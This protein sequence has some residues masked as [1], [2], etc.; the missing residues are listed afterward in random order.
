MTPISGLGEEQKNSGPCAGPP[1]NN[2]ALTSP[3]NGVT[4]WRGN[5]SVSVPKENYRPAATAG[6]EPWY[7]GSVQLPQTQG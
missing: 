1:C 5:H 7:L 4:R 2:N 6:G 3:A